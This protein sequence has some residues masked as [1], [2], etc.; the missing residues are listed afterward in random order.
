MLLTFDEVSIVYV[1]SR[2]SKPSY[3]IIYNFIIDDN[4]KS[5]YF[6]CAFDKYV[7]PTPD[8]CSVLKAK[9]GIF[10]NE[11]LRNG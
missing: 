5:L 10:Q 3:S 11:R 8:L 1:T 2:F 6:M 4:F 7:Y 9:F